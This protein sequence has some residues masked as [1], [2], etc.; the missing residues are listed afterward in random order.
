MDYTKIH[1]ELIYKDRRD[2]DDFPVDEGFDFQSMEE[3]F[4]DALENRPFIKESENAPEL[5]L[6]IFNNARYI[7]TLIL[8]ENHPNHYLLKYLR[9]AAEDYRSL[10]ISNHV[11][12]ATMALVWNYLFHYFTCYNNSKIVDII[13]DN[14]NKDDWKYETNGGQDD[15]FKLLIKTASSHPRW[16]TDSNFDPRDIKSVVVEE[17]FLFD[18]FITKDIDYVISQIFGTLDDKDIPDVLRIVENRID[19]YKRYESDDNVIY[20]ETAYAYSKLKEAYYHCGMKWDKETST[21]NETDSENKF[22]KEQITQQ[23]AVDSSEIEAQLAAAQDHI[24]DLESKNKELMDFRQEIEELKG[25]TENKKLGID[26]LAIF[27]SSAVGLD[28]DP[29][30]T[31]QKQLSAMISTMCGN[32]PESIRARISKMNQ[33]EKNNNFSDEVR[34]AARNVK[35][36]LEKISRGNQP[37]KLKD[38]ID[39]IDLVFLNSK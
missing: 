26:E 13:T 32:T 17:I 9:I 5:I 20:F 39:N 33:M 29:T 30:R 11:M 22:D 37:Q 25:L 38:I 2:L 28:F 8:L 27:F 18:E 7:T 12:P 31:N 10:I 21:Q 36:L 35:G 34:Q 6:K 4:L 14:F 24:R 19:Q 15:F 16:L 1:R 23:P 3:V